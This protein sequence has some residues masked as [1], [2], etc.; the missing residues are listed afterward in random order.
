MSKHKYPRTRK[1]D[2][3]ETFFGHLL[4]DPYRWLHNA[5]DSEVLSWVAEQN[6]FTDSWFD[7][8]E[9]EA[10]IQKSKA[11]KPKPIYQNIAPWKDRLTAGVME[12]GD[13]RIVSVN[14]QFQDEKLLLKRNDI[15]NFLPSNFQA[16]P[17]DGRIAAVSGIVEGEARMTV[18]ALDL[19]N[20]RI[21]GQIG[22][23]FS[24][25]WSLTRPVIYYAATDTDVKRQMT[26]TRACAYDAVSGQTRILYEDNTGAII[27]SAHVSSDKTHVMFEMKQDYSNSRFIAYDETADTLSF[28]N[29]DK[30]A[31][32]SYI[33]SMEGKHYFISREGAPNGEVLCVEYGGSI[34]DSHTVCSEKNKVLENA[35]V[36]DGRLYLLYMKNV[37]SQLV[38]AAG[39]REE[40]I[41]LPS[42][43]GTAQ[44]A[45]RDEKTVYL[46]FETFLD[47]P[48]LLA[49]HCGN[50]RVAMRQDF[51]AWPEL[52]VEQKYAPSAGDGK[53]IPYFIVRRKDAVPNGQN[54][55]W[56]YAYGGY[57]LAMRPCSSEPD[58]TMS[59][60]Q[61]VSEGGIY[62][63]G[64]I[65]GGSEFG[66]SW[67]EEGMLDQK[68]NCYYDF[69][70]IAEQLIREGWT[71]PEK[72]VISGRSNGGLLMSVLVTMR[73]DLFGCVIDSVPHTDM[74]HFS[75]DDRGPMYITEYGNPLESEEMFQY[76]LS[77]SPYH[78]VK[79][80][81]YPPV[82]IQT[83]ECDNN[84]PPYHAKK[85]AARM[86]ELNQSGNPI[87]LRVLEKGAHD[88]GSGKVF[89]RTVS[90]MQ[91][92]VRKA[93]GI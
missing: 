10:A 3:K 75:Q 6:A 82:Y 52:M 84:V 69:I 74:I 31:Q 62:V 35:F 1:S 53:D 42:G 78:N 44:L 24:Y 67:H 41:A 29:P 71:K 18:I 2:D 89:W 91:L 17:T 58:T 23:I 55:L 8:E 54:P 68:K 77:Y 72:F 38:C 64:S 22:N 14:R 9:L 60:A 81:S 26:T 49:L 85:F 19:E 87:L 12:D 47:R 79:K 36:L 76:M 21:L 32:M 86:Q 56:M 13:H 66:V 34:Q 48:V 70:G 16:C 65:R 4:E 83:G 92:F 59:I 28:I 15:P 93:L 30:A 33:D 73:P 25:A 63:L 88:R 61:W 5:R 39:D 27:G 37:C 57:N 51:N 7:Q 80:T 90:E 45:G 11:A 46:S 20:Q 43:M 50:I 40:E